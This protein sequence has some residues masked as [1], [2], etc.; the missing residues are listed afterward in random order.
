MI[1][2]L[3]D[4]YSQNSKTKWIISILVILSIIF[5][6]G[7]VYIII[8]DIKEREK[9]TIELY[10]ICNKSVRIIINLNDLKKTTLWVPGWKN[11]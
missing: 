6:I 11:L 5:S 7:Y 1:K 10:A 2:D 4:F 8:N 9:N 3:S